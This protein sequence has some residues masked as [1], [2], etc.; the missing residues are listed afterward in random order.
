MLR[1]DAPKVSGPTPKW[2]QH[3]G[4]EAG[5]LTMNTS[6]LLREKQYGGNIES[7]YTH[8]HTHTHR[9]LAQVQTASHAPHD[10]GR[11]GVFA[12]SFKTN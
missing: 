6:D 5:T 1:E 3:I 12:S 9:A 4:A 7:S 11:S 2:R 10:A 8:T